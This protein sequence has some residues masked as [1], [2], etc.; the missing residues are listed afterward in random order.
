MLEVYI[1]GFDVTNLVVGFSITRS[2]DLSGGLST[3]QGSLTVITR[4]NEDYKRCYEVVFANLLMTF[5]INGFVKQTDGTTLI[6]MVQL[7]EQYFA[8]QP[9]YSKKQLSEG[10]GV[11]ITR[12]ALIADIL[13]D[14]SVPYSISTFG[15]K[16]Y[17]LVGDVDSD[18]ISVA[19]SI[20]TPSGWL[21][22]VEPN[23]SQV[24][25]TSYNSFITK[26]AVATGNHIVET[27]GLEETD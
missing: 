17:D 1:N 22:Y 27:A 9:V 15:D 13:S 12:S 7:T 23:N 6:N 2:N 25:F 4:V 10:K 19:A 3:L 18:P 11:G 16:Q 5:V 21:T 8:R 26:Q 14:F 24:R 20:A